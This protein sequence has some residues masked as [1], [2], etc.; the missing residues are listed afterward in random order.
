MTEELIHANVRILTMSRVTA[1]ERVVPTAHP[2]GCASLAVRTSTVIDRRFIDGVQSY[3]LA[4]RSWFTVPNR[5]RQKNLVSFSRADV[6]IIGTD[7]RSRHRASVFYA[8]A[9]T[10]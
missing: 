6:Y 8:Y 7:S 5:R 3:T 2:V 4:H 9:A 1:G 10:S